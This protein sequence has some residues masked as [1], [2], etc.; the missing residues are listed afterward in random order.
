MYDVCKY[1]RMHVYNVGM[2]VCM[3][4]CV[5]VCAC[6]CMPVFVYVCICM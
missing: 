1:I 5:N 6:A 2:C 4:A 3:Q